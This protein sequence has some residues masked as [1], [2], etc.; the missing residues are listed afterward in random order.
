MGFQQG[1]SGL[2]ASSKALDATGNNIANAGTVGFKSAR[3]QFADVFAASLSGSGASQVGVGTSLSS[4]PQQFTQGGITTSNNPLDLAINGNGFYLMSN[5]GAVSYSRNGQFQLD[6]DGFVVNS[7]GYRLQ[8]VLADRLTGEINS[9]E[10]PTDLYVDPRQQDP[11]QT[12]DIRMGLNLDSREDIPPAGHTAFKLDDPLSYNKST[13]QTIYDSLGNPH[14][15][16]YYFVKDFVPGDPTIPTDASPVARSW[17]LYA[18]I[19]GT[20]IADAA[21][22]PTTNV[23]LD[24]NGTAIGGDG[25]SLPGRAILVFD[26][27]GKLTAIN[28]NPVAAG[29][30]ITTTI[31]LD[32]VMTDLGK[33][34][35][36]SSPLTVNLDVG[37]ITQFGSPFSVTD[38][39]QDGYSSGRL[40]GISIDTDGMIQGRYSN[41]QTRNQGQIVLATFKNP[42]GLQSMGG[43]QW[44]SSAASGDP[45]VGNPG[46]GLNGVI[47]SAAVEESNVDLTAELV[48]MITQQRSYQANAQTIRTQDQILQ[49]LVNLR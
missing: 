16:S 27:A 46:S 48:N 34:N 44:Q 28:G 30:T 12:E 13:S 25:V 7:A 38:M 37:S 10:T 45:L 31:D 24:P 6:K 23:T 39:V 20:P 11:A 32:T 40:S 33:V 2:N 3:A 8:G 19:D 5:N 43:N 29:S 47:Q 49:T 42:N 9:G 4:V 15:L 1:L 26:S 35:S 41:G 36:A 14:V 22:H 17:Q 21:T 18:T